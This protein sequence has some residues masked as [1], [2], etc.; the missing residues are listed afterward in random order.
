MNFPYLLPKIWKLNKGSLGLFTLGVM[1]WQCLFWLG[2]AVFFCLFWRVL[3]SEGD[4]RLDFQVC[5]A[6]CEDEICTGLAS[7]INGGKS[8]QLPL[9]LRLTGWNCQSN[10]KYN[11]MHQVHRLSNGLWQK[12]YGKWPFFRVF[13]IQEVFSVIFS[14][15]N[16]WAHWQGWKLLCHSLANSPTNHPSSRWMLPLYRQYYLSS[17]ATWTFST[18]FHARDVWLTEKLDYFGAAW[19]IFIFCHLTICRTLHIRESERQANLLLLVQFAFLLHVCK[20]MLH[21]FDYGYNM[22]VLSVVGAISISLWLFW[23]AAGVDRKGEC[24]NK[25]RKYGNY[26]IWCVGLFVCSTV[27]LEIRDF[28]PLW[29]WLDAHALWHLSTIPITLKWYQFYAEDVVVS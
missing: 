17:L 1:N 15:G 11:C 29:G 20:M 28:P 21:S 9:I 14:I 27:M 8:A 18:F 24:R 13:G 10:C 4:E 2:T 7:S 26:P 3:A 6:E 22:V 25:N 5:L 19:G 16:G 12:Y 23:W